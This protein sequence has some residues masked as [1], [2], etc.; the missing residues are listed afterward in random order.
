MRR[1]FARMNPTL[2]GFLII[3]L[4]VIVV[5][6]LN[7]YGTL[8]AL[9]ILLRVAFFLAIAFFIFLMWRERRDEI[10]GW[11]TRE[12]IVFYGSALLIVAAIGSYF[13]HGLPGYDALAFIGVIACAGYAMFRVWRDRHTYS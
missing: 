3:A 1:L 7:L 8:A 6:V 9:G 13:W 4:I 11:D 2:R 12:R 10:G 5:M